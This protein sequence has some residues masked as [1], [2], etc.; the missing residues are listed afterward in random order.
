[1]KTITE[2]S[3]VNKS[4]INMLENVEIDVY[5]YQKP[6]KL[7]NE[8]VKELRIIYIAIVDV[9]VR[10]KNFQIKLT[11]MRYNFGLAFSG[12]LI[13]YKI[14][15]HLHEEM[16]DFLEYIDGTKDVVKMYDIENM[17]DFFSRRINNILQPLVEQSLIK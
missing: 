5:T 8:T 12:D 2:L 15:E 13:E 4:V 16:K 3:V 9:F 7:Y 1:M 11:P 14:L 6:K 17:K 10:C